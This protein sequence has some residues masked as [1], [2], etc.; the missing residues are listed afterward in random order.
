MI[1]NCPTSNYMRM[2]QMPPVLC[3]SN[4]I[5]KLMVRRGIFNDLARVS[6]C[7]DL[8]SPIFSATINAALKPMEAISR[9][10]NNPNNDDLLKST[11]KSQHNN[12]DDARNTQSGST[13]TEATNAQVSLTN[14]KFKRRAKF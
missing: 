1:E 3:D 5:I 13:S 12:L 6:H 2:F 7:I 9:V 8:S 11:K 4:Y 14:I 10:I